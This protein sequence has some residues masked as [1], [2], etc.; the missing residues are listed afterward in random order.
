MT[1]Q[2]ILK[3]EP[4]FRRLN[5]IVNRYGVDGAATFYNVT[6]DEIKELLSKKN[7]RKAVKTEP[8]A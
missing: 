7:E 6:T 1:V 8:E 5:N 2:Q 3:S 4:R